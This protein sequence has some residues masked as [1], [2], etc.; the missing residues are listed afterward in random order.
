MSH[1]TIYIMIMY[2]IIFIIMFIIIMLVIKFITLQRT[3]KVIAIERSRTAMQHGAALIE[4]HLSRLHRH[5]VC[6]AIVRVH[7]N[8]PRLVHLL[9]NIHDARHHQRQSVHVYEIAMT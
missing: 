4:H 1:Y 8:G 3:Y 7:F 6:F 9:V 5:V 2:I